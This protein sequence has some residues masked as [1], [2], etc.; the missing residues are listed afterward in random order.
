M[1]I[2]ELDLDYELRMAQA[3]LRRLRDATIAEFTAAAEVEKNPYMRE[4]YLAAVERARMI[5]PRS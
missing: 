3:S 5:G 2:E 4:T 1:T